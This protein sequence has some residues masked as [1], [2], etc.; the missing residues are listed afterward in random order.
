[1]AKKEAK[2]ERKIV[3][4]RTYIIPLRKKFRRAPNYKRTPR[5]VKA[6]R[7]FALRHMKGKRISIGKYLNN[8][9]WSRGM[10]NPPHKVKVDCTRDEDGIVKVELFGAPK[11]NLLEEKKQGKKEDIKDESKEEVEIKVKEALGGD[12]EKEP[13]TAQKIE[14][15]EIDILKRETHKVHP[16]KDTARMKQSKEHHQSPLPSGKQMGV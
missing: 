14:K 10:K 5:A 7:E 13:E 12:E 15:E 4:E 16:P 8:M 2:K 3:L 1:M 9:L 11:E 6:V